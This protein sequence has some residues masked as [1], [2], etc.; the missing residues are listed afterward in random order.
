M[1]ERHHGGVCH[2]TP[3]YFAVV[4]LRTKPK[5]FLISCL[6]SVSETM[7]GIVIHEIQIMT[8]KSNQYLSGKFGIYFLFAR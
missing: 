4:Y 6:H 3:Y 2:R 7:V 5:K 1:D 8:S